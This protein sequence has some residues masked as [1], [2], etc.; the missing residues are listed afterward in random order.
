MQLET[1]SKVYSVND[2]DLQEVKFYGKMTGDLMLN[3]NFT[4]IFLC[5][6]ILKI[7]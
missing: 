3:Q 2:Q 7:S 6:V 5:G 4:L 1:A